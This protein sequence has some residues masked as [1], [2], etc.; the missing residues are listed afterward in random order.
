M[1][2]T[3]HQ[4]CVW[5]AIKQNYMA[6]KYIKEPTPELCKSA[7]DIDIDAEKNNDMFYSNSAFL[8]HLC[9]ILSKTEQTP[10]LCKV[11]VG[12][13]EYALQYVKEQTPG[14][15]ELAIKQ[16]GHALK[17]VKEQTPELCKFAIKQHCCNC[18]IIYNHL[19][20]KHCCKC[21]KVYY[22]QLGKHCCSCNMEYAFEHCCK[23]KT[24]YRNGI[25]ECGVVDGIVIGDTK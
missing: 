14:L 10:E 3:R 11:I 16:N 8:E 25:H 4:S 22:A 5:L 18:N 6:L 13:H 2:K 17:H 24:R 19:D 1:S 20:E 7:I 21:K 15:C 23:C 12:Y 9:V